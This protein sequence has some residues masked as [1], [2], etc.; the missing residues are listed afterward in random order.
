MAKAR[1]GT[2][3]LW[4]GVRR[5]RVLAAPEPDAPPIAVT[6]PAAWD[7]GAATAL[8]WMAD[9]RHSL[10]LADLAEG[11]LGPLAAADPEL[12]ARMHG[13]L[14]RRRAA[15][16]A[17]S[18]R[19]PDEAPRWRLNFG[20]F[21]DDM[22]ALEAAGADI[23]AS[24]AALASSRAGGTVEVTG[25]DALLAGQ[26]L[27]YAAPAARAL[28]QDMLRRLRA[29]LGL[30]VRLTVGAPDPADD[31]LG[32]ETSG[33]A[34]AFSP[35]RPD[36][37]LSRAARDRLAARGIS[38]EAAL[39]AALHGDDPLPVA[40]HAAHLAMADALRPL[41]DAMPPVPRPL[42]RP[43]A[44][45]VLPRRRGGLAQRASVGGQKVYV[46]TGEFADGAPG[47]VSIS[48]PQASPAARA[49]ADALGHAI[50]IG[51]QHGAPLA[52]FLEALVGTRFG[53]AG[54]VEGD[55]SVALATSPL[56]YVARTLAAAYLPE[57]RLPAAEFE[58]DGPPPLLPLDLPQEPPPPRRRALRV[59]K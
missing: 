40:D 28:A 35:V 26:G 31:L 44:R 12:A 49:L 25:L 7:D 38:P 24:L 50:T 27:D 33:I 30:R 3:R 56:D 45:K 54:A 39:G 23:A 29:A 32:V 6:L 42:A 36:G 34:P 21:V 59:V 4:D 9:G 14:L 15:P 20:A 46:V 16:A 17:A 22:P 10:D 13:L 43:T 2:M 1:S 18:W 47:E 11:W 37:A 58:H 5:R 52:D 48:L 19:L 51:L 8:A 55:P 57:L 41:L 53:A